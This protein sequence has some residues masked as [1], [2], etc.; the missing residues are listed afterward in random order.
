MAPYTYCSTAPTCKSAERVDDSRQTIAR[1]RRW[2]WRKLRL[3]VDPT[4]GMIVAQT[5]MDQ[6]ADDRAGSARYSIK[7]TILLYQTT[8]ELTVLVYSR[9][10]MDR[11]RS[12]MA[13]S[14]FH[15]SQQASTMAS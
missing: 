4:N 7:L 14:L 6:G 13:I 11:I 10:A 15:A 8:H 12:G 5:L 3:A 9:V 2:T 1:N